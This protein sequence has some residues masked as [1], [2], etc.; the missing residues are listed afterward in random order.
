MAFTTGSHKEE[1]K[2]GTELRPEEQSQVLRKKAN[3][4]KP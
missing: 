1:S 4:A 3:R 2:V